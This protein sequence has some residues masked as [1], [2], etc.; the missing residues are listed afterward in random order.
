M[1]SPRL[2]GIPVKVVGPVVCCNDIRLEAGME[3]QDMVA[4]LRDII[5]W[6]ALPLA[7]LRE[8]C[9][10]AGIPMEVTSDLEEVPRFEAD[11][12]PLALLLVALV[13]S[14][15]HSNNVISNHIEISL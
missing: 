6:Q 12:R 11:A 5:V 13:L 4:F 15:Y 10:R 3:K 2:G 7:Q 9:S 1:G 8:D 14:G